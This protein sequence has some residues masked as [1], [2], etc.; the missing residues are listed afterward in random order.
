MAQSIK[1]TCE[2]SGMEYPL[3]AFTIY[4]DT[5]LIKIYANGLVTGCPTQ[6]GVINFIPTIAQL[7]SDADFCLPWDQWR[8]DV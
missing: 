5:G 6:R 4:T 8:P 2:S 1:E 3:P 7:G